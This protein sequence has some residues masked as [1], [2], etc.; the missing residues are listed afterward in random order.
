MHSEYFNT[1][2]GA[3]FLSHSVGLMPHAA[4]RE[5]DE[6]FLA[7]WAAG[8]TGIWD[9]WLAIADRFRESLAPLIGAQVSDIC[10]Q[11]NISS[12]LSKILYS[13]KPAAGRKKIV[14]CEEDFPTVGFALSRCGQ[15]GLEPVFINSGRH[16][17]DPDAWSEGFG[18]DVHILHV[19]HVFSN[20]GLKSPVR[21]IVARARSKGVITIVDA[22][23]SAGAVAVDAAAWG[24]DFL[25][26]TSLKYLCGGP[27]A[28]FLWVN[29][30][31]AGKCAPVDVGWF[32]HENPFEFDIR[33]FRYAKGATRFWGGTP[34][35]APLAAAL[36][37]AKLIGSAGVRGIETHNQS[38]F[39]RV[40]KKIPATSFLSHT[41][42]GE[43]GSSFIIR[44]A[45]KA[46]AAA[47]MRE[48]N[49][50]FDERAGGLRFSLHLYNDEA[51][52]DLLAD[53][54][55]PFL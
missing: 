33:R 29:P 23:Q 35:V 27:G 40:T 24:A 46:D 25:T 53:T 4:R 52:V 6:S 5:I 32:S 50:A 16:L 43:R 26:G 12:A 21:E 42:K 9:K 3:Y 20:L 7:P 38:L 55:T 47:A 49:I 2:A 14:L 51:D 37:G 8:E 31:I 45:R 10:P 13:L 28:A 48:A 44:P 54:L 17:V 34:S 41:A 1:P 39:D 18:D 11:T 22:A 36:A 19:T 15:L 30:E